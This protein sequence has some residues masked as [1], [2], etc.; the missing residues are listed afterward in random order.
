[1]D[2]ARIAAILAAYGADP[3]RWPEAERHAAQAWAAAN[4]A[5]FEALAADARA[6][7]ALLASDARDSAPGDL[8]R[9][10][11]LRAAPKPGAF[12]VR[13]VAALAASA[14]LG[15]LIGFSGVSVRGVDHAGADAAFDA[16]LGFVD[17]GS[18]G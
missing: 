13:A 9:A 3:A 11:I 17:D 16:A 15:V 14:V 8:L 5:R 18:G 7:D 4:A 1:M 10:R 6:V 2:E 12:G